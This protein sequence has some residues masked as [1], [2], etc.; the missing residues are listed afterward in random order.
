MDGFYHIR[1]P[2]HQFK[3]GTRHSHLWA[4]ALRQVTLCG[5]QGLAE[6]LLDVL[7]PW[8]SNRQ[9]AL[10]GLENGVGEVLVWHRMWRHPDYEARMSAFRGKPDV[11]GHPSER[12]L[13]AMSGHSSNPMQALE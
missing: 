4:C 7:E 3:A 5:P 10:S 2:I 6:S 9:I 12:L 8:D 13:I 1:T 11:F